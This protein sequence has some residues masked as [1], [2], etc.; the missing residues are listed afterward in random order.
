MEEDDG[1]E[2]HHHFFFEHEVIQHTY[3]QVGDSYINVFEGGVNKL[4]DFSSVVVVMPIDFDGGAHVPVLVTVT[5]VGRYLELI[6]ISVD[7][8]GNKGVSQIMQANFGN[9]LQFFLFSEP[10]APGQKFVKPLGDLS[11]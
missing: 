10:I 9:R 6:N 8:H 5:A 7:A 4:T 3:R 11:R 2:I 1:S